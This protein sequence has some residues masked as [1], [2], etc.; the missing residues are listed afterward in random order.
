[1]ILLLVHPHNF[2]NKK[3]SK[4]PKNF[5]KTYNSILYFGKMTDTADSTTTN[6][7][8]N[9]ALLITGK[10]MQDKND[11]C[12]PEMT[13][14]ERMIGFISCVAIG[15]LLDFMSFIMMIASQGNNA[16]TRFAIFYSLG[17]I[18][19]LFA[20]TFLKGIKSQIRQMKNPKRLIVTIVL[21]SSIIGII[22]VA[23]LV[24]NE[25]LKRLIIMI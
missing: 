18:L 21:L 24:K 14:K 20:I 3:Y 22:L 6:L 13:F 7:I 4:F 1:M 2:F 8:D 15:Y 19:S 12:F 25:K 16:T 5:E 10:P 11:S 23:L 17:N 9:A